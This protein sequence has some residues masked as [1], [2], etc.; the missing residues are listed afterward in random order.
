MNTKDIGWI[1]GVLDGEGCI[2]ASKPWKKENDGMTRKDGGRYHFAVIVIITNTSSLLLEK[3]GKILREYSIEYRYVERETTHHPSYIT[4]AKKPEVLKFLSLVIEDL[5]C[6]KRSA[7]EVIKFISKWPYTP[8][9][10]GIKIGE[11][12]A[13]KE[14]VNDYIRLYNILKKQKGKGPLSVETTRYTSNMD[15]DIVRYSK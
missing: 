14:K 10:K 6:K 2:Y 4:I 13:S 7:E 8:V 11:N 3:V 9:T 15:E 1:A 5:T 12:A